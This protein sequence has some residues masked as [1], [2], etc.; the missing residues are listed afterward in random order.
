LT[1]YW[2]AYYDDYYT[3]QY[4]NATL[5][6]SSSR[7]YNCHGYA[8]YKSEGGAAVWIGYSTPGSEEVFWNDGSYAEVPTA[9]STK[10]SYTGDHSAV[11]TSTTDVYISKWNMYPLMR[12]HKDYTPGYGSANQFF[13]RSVDVPQEYSSIPSALAAAVSGQTVHVS[14]SQ[15]LSGDVTVPSGITLQI[16]SGTTQTFTGNYKLRIEGKLTASGTTFTR[17]GGQWYGIEFYNGSSESSIS[18]STI[19]NAQYGVYTYGTFVSISDCSIKNNTTGVYVYNNSTTLSH[20]LVQD[21]TYGFNCASYGDPNIVPNNVLKLN[22]WAVYTDATSAPNLGVYTGYNSIY[23]N[24]YYDVYSNYSGTIYARG[25]WWGSYPAAPSYYGTLDYSNAFSYDING[26]LAETPGGNGIVRGLSKL[27][28]TPDTSGMRELDQAYK[29]YL[30]NDYEAA[31]SSFQNIATRYRDAFVGSRALVF[32]DRILEKLGRDAKPDLRAA[33]NGAP[34]SKTA[35]VA[36]FLL[37]NELVKEG[38]YEEALGNAVSLMNDP[39]KSFVKDALYNAGNILWYKL[40]D[41]ETGK[42]Y[43]TRLTAEFPDDPLS[44]SAKSTLGGFAPP[45]A[46]P[47]LAGRQ[48]PTEYVL[49]TNNYPN[50]FNPS[51]IIRYTLPENGHT[52]LK[53]FDLLGREVAILVNEFKVAG[54]HEARFDAS[55][56]PSGVYVYRLEI[57]GKSL[58]QKMTLLR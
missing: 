50:P 42:S 7:K 58:V 1:N 11:T 13:R 53:V 31:L 43:L 2:I 16:N 45:S 4:P 37:V 32:M 12:H 20:N 5:I 41:R 15:T 17:S 18:Y 19:Q 28:A 38:S 21:N 6:S 25:N 23:S 40:G 57:A 26:R 56:L 14:N 55:S 8:W 39:N 10:V 51:T 47:P 9:V 29:L 54:T 30:N 36:R 48:A 44:A 46:K 35:S 24:D 27:G 22:S 49:G 33:M 34:G 52:S 3:S